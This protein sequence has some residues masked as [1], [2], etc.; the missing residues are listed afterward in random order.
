MSHET[1]LM[2][3]LKRDA[4]GSGSL[5]EML[6][7]AL[8]RQKAIYVQ[9]LALAKQQSAHVAAGESEELMTVLGARSRLIQEVAP[10]DQELQPYKGLWQQVLDGLPSADR[11]L[12]GQLLQEVQRL[13]SEILEQDERDKESLMR[14]KSAVGAELNRSVSGAAL[15]RAYGV[16]GGMR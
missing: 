1:L 10:I 6:R 3:A 9:I 7:N 14:Q 8:S 4:S 2:N 5:V 15:N 12:V 16:A 13:L 11:R